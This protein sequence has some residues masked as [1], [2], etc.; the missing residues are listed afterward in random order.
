MVNIQSAT[1]EEKRRKKKK[2]EEATAVKY[3]DRI[4]YTPGGHNQLVSNS[5]LSVL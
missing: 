4:C 3:N 5:K 2:E 1:A